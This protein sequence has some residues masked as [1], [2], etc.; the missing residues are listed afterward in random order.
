MSVL[1]RPSRK[2]ASRI[3]NE[4]DFEDRIIG[5]RL[6]ERTGPLAMTLYSFEEVVTFLRDP[7]PRV[8]FHALQSW[9]NDVMGD[10]ELALM[11]GIRQDN[12]KSGST[13]MAVSLSE[14]DGI[15]WPIGLTLEDADLRIAG[16]IRD[17]AVVR[18][19]EGI[20]ATYTKGRN[21]VFWRLSVEHI[22]GL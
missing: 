11:H 21:I 18:S 17:P 8:N 16:S 9:I 1:S 3:V 22:R 14:D 10:G 20:S 6:R 5:Y 7:F 12:G 2:L 4:V 19:P 13:R 15:T